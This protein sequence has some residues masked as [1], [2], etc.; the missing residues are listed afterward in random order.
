MSAK[1]KGLIAAILALIVAVFSWYV[2]YS[3]NDPKTVPNTG[4]V[5]EAGKDVVKAATAE[6]PGVPEN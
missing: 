1:V 2:A 4:A 6:V 3:D 5:I